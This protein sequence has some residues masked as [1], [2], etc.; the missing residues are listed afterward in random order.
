MV[1][2]GTRATQEAAAATVRAGPAEHR[3]RGREEAL[4]HRA[5]EATPV[6]AAILARAP[7]V[8]PAPEVEAHRDRAAARAAG[9]P[10]G[11]VAVREVA[12]IPEAAVEARGREGARAAPVLRDQLEARVAQARPTREAAPDFRMAERRRP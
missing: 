11:R 1:R 3:A 12:E 8:V 4:V 9:A 10:R 7:E 5:R 6:A 2:R